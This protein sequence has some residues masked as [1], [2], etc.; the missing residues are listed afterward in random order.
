MEH[1][2]YEVKNF[3]VLR[4]YTLE[5]RFDDGITN[6]VNFD[7]ALEGELYGPMK[8]PFLFERVKLDEESG[9]L[10]WPND[11]DF[12]PEILH[13]WPKRRAAFIAAAQ[14][15]K[16]G[17]HHFSSITF[18][19]AGQIAQRI[20]SLEKELNL[21]LQRGDSIAEKQSIARAA[22]KRRIS[23]PRKAGPAPPKGTE[24]GNGSLRPAVMAI[25]KKSKKPLR[26]ADIYDALVAQGYQFTFREPK[27]V[28]RNRLYRMFGV[29]AFGGGLFK[30]K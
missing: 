20:E 10:V 15:W 14:K 18:A 23:A 1:G 11:A 24:E 16:T 17:R 28:L 4:P 7:G 5:I 3:K 19:K 6:V 29:H 9:N 25:L 12:D 21:L 8:D 22:L 2:L 27:K 13:D 30:A 26:T